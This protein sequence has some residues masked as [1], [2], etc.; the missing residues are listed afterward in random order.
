MRQQNACSPQENFNE[1]E[2]SEVLKWQLV[3]QKISC[4]H[5]SRCVVQTPR[6]KHKSPP[7]PPYTGPGLS[8]KFAGE[9]EFSA[10]KTRKEAG[11]QKKTRTRTRFFACQTADS[12]E[13]KRKFCALGGRG[14]T[15]FQK[16]KTSTKTFDRGTSHYF[17][18]QNNTICLYG[19]NRGEMF[20]KKNPLAWLT[21]PKSAKSKGITK[22][23]YRFL[24]RTLDTIWGP[25]PSVTP[26]SDQKC[27]S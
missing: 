14:N 26:D 10:K 6:P 15:N 4:L 16:N 8:S 18:S 24:A 11:L 12:F 25:P 20:W 5:V 27:H 13:M 1:R 7:P 21:S 3:V 23:G 2:R 9:N 22:S 17:S 19:K